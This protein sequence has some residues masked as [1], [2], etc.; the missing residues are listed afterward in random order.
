ME[1]DSPV[2][3][4]SSLSGE[5]L[6]EPGERVARAKKTGEEEDEEEEEEEEESGEFAPFLKPSIP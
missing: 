2:V 6:P 5:K 1:E 3:T 4:L